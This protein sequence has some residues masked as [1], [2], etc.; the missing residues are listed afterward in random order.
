MALPA[1]SNRPIF[2]DAAYFIALLLEDDDLHARALARGIEFDGEPLLTTD[3]VLVEV[4]ASVS[5]RGSRVRAAAL[6]LLDELR[7]SPRISIVHQTPTLFYAGIEL[8]K[9]R[10]DKAYSLTDCMSMVTCSERGITDV[11]THDRHFQQ[12]GFSIL[13]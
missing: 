11:L 13:L 12:E 8:Y 3:A 5:R 6:A 10:P 2:A 9:A 4:F 1:K 7:A